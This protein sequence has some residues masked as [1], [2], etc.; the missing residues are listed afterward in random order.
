METLY[1]RIRT[2]DSGLLRPQKLGILPNGSEIKWLTS[3]MA[4]ISIRIWHQ[5]PGT[6]MVQ[7]DALSRR[8]DH[9]TEGQFDD[10]EKTVLPENLFI[11]LLDTKLQERIL[12]GKEIDLDVKNAMETLLEEGPTNYE[13]IFMTGRLKKLTEE[14]WY[15]TK[16][17]TIFQKIMNYD[18]ILWRCITII[19]WQD[20]QKN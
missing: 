16:E 4:A 11:N 15:S 8:P 10:K 18:E 17:R 2:H 6:K 14:E 12:N 13:T 20:T 1:P 9:G 7:S 5:M 3:K 19:K